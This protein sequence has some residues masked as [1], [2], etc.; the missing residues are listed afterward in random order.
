MRVL[1]LA[2]L[3]LISL[4]AC[5][6]ATAPGGTTDPNEPVP[7]ESA[8]GTLPPAYAGATIAATLYDPDTGSFL[9][10][11]GTVSQDG[12]FELALPESV[13]TEFLVSA[14]ETFGCADLPTFAFTQVAGLG[15]QPLSGDPEVALPVR[16]EVST[17]EFP[18]SYYTY[19]YSDRSVEV[20][21]RCTAS[22]AGSL[23][24]AAA[25]ET[26]L[27][28]NLL[29]GWNLVHVTEGDGRLTLETLPFLGYIVWLLL[30]AR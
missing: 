19:V 10:V 7:V 4:T 24:S 6:R 8:R 22:E 26:R 15:V 14:G 27:S 3:L 30:A 20:D 13:P 17:D 1:P 23:R 12:T 16:D 2:L 9:D 11:T 21:A 28:L 18:T 25:A 29:T 5:G